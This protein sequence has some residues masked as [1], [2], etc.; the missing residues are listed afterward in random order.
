MAMNDVDFKFL[1][2]A[3]PAG[4]DNQVEY[5]RGTVHVTASLTAAEA[6]AIV[7]ASDADRPGKVQTAFGAA[8][9]SIPLADRQTLLG[10][11]NGQVARSKVLVAP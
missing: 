3:S 2:D 9:A 1:V 11:V 7:T 6:R 4:L 10:L 5:H 8:W